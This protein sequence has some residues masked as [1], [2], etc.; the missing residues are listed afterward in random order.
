MLVLYL[1]QIK[2]VLNQV[3]IGFLSL[4]IYLEIIELKMEKIPTI[5]YFDSAQKLT[6][7]NFDKKIPPEIKELVLKLQK[8]DKKLQFLWNDDKLQ[9]KNTECGVYCI[10]FIVNMLEGLIFK[11]TLIQK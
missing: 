7:K 5:Y 1:I 6:P 11:I 3:N 2:K 4:S 9:Y 8:Q 10:H